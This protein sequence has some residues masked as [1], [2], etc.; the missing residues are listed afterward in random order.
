[1][2][3]RFIVLALLGSVLTGCYR[4]TVNTGAPQAAT[5]IENPWQMSFAAGLVPPPEINTQAE[6][7][8]GVA[9]VQTQRSFLNALA[10][11]V[12][13]QILTPMDARVIC[14]QG[15]VQP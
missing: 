3:Y 13:S 12:T 5:R 15:P 11:V 10:A 4:V 6:C 7:P 14:A 1:M 9:Q 2:P 8:M